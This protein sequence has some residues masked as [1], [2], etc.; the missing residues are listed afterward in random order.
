MKLLIN[1]KMNALMVTGTQASDVYEE[2]LTFPSISPVGLHVG[3]SRCV[4]VRV[5]TRFSC[6]F[7]HLL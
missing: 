4:N 7:H 5:L 1:K 3:E 6:H 2:F